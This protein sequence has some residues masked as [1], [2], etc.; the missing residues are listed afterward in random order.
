[1]GVKHTTLCPPSDVPGFGR[2]DAPI[3]THLCYCDLRNENTVD[4]NRK[5]IFFL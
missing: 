2:P 1:M 3:Q 4:M 5:V